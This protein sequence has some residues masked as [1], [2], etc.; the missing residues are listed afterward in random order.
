MFAG[1]ELT[2]SLAY[3]KAVVLVKCPNWYLLHNSDPLHWK[4]SL[5]HLQVYVWANNEYRLALHR[6]FMVT[7]V[8]TKGANI[9]STLSTIGWIEHKQ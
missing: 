6:T 4:H 2:N 5:R 9:R 7:S 3:Q 1:M 8:L